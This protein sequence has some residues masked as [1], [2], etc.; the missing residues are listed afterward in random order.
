MDVLENE[1]IVSKSEITLK[2]QCFYNLIFV[3]NLD[4][5]MCHT[6]TITNQITKKPKG[7]A[8]EKPPIRC[9]QGKV[10]KNNSLPKIQF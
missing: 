7:D 9:W 4:I 1:G 3:N 6:F 8:L 2:L 10:D 5:L